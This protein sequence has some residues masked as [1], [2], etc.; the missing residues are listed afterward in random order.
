MSHT[1]QPKIWDLKDPESIVLKVGED[2]VFMLDFGRD[3]DVSSWDFSAKY[4][5]YRWPYSPSSY[6]LL[7]SNEL[8]AFDLS[9]AAEGII[10]LSADETTVLLWRDRRISLRIYADDGSRKWVASDRTIMTSNGD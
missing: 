5:E 7:L 6:D 2:A 4:S 1:L 9:E 8:T 3:Q 10:Y